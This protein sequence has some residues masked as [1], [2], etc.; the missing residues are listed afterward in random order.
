MEAFVLSTVHSVWWTTTFSTRTTR[1]PL[2]G[3]SYKQDRRQSFPG[4][5]PLG[6]LGG[7][8]SPGSS[9]PDPISDQKMLFS[10]PVFR[11]EL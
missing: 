7:G 6:I 5:V 2:H 4:G 10:I 8:V 9:N 1:L 11:L 3:V